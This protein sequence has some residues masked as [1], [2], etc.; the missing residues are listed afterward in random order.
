MYPGWRHIGSRYA[1]GAQ[2]ESQ[3]K[4]IVIF[5]VSSSTH[6]LVCVVAI[7]ALYCVMTGIEKMDCTKWMADSLRHLRNFR[8]NKNFM[9]DRFVMECRKG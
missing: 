4:G 3:W 9:R 2:S 8:K 1:D 7:R 5:T 6:S